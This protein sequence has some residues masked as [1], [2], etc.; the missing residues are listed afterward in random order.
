MHR[1]ALVLMITTAITL[2]LKGV[3]SEKSVQQEERPKIGLA[4]SGGGARGAAHIGVIRVLGELNIPIDYIAGT[5]MGS[6][7]GGLYA[8]GMST[9]EME[10]QLTSVDWLASFDDVSKR[11]DKT[12]RRKL[13]DS[14]YLVKHKA[15]ISDEG[16]LK[17]PGGILQGQR[18]DLLLSKFT[19]PVSHVKN[20]DKLSIPFRAVAADIETGDSVV[21]STGSLA[22]A[23]RASMN[24]PG[25][26]A[27]VTIDGK[28]LVDGGVA[29]NLPINVVR[30]MGADI[31]IAIDISTP[32]YNKEQLKNV[33]NISGQLVG[34]LTRKNTEYSLATLTKKDI[35]IIPQ[36]GDIGTGDFE[37]AGET[38]PVGEKAARDKTS[39]LQRLKLP[40]NQ[41]ELH[42]AKRGQRQVAAP[43]IAFI[44]VDN[45]SRLH[46]DVIKSKVTHKTGQPLDV[47]QI[48]N[49]IGRIYGLNQFENV[50][51]ELVEENGESGVVIHAVEKNW[52]PNY[53]QF[54]IIISDN[55]EGDNSVNL[56]AAY[57]RTGI[58]RLNGEWRTALQV[59]EDPL[60]LTEIYQPL[61][62]ANKFFINASAF[63]Q[64]RNLNVFQSAGNQ[65]G[66]YRV[67][68]LATS[69]AVGMNFDTWGELRFGIRRTSGEA[70]VRVGGSALSD[71]NFDSGSFL[72]RFSF[73]TI[74]D[75]YFPKKGH[76]GLL[77]GRFFSNSLGGDDNFD[78]L[79]LE[80][81]RAK[82]WGRN[83]FL[84]GLKY[85]TTL[86]DD[87]PIY[88]LFQIGGFTNL[89]G[90]NQGELTGQHTGVLRLG[91]LRRIND[92]KLL[93]TYFGASL[94][95]GGAWQESGDIFDEG[96]AAASIFIGVDSPI[97]PI[98]TGYGHAEG[99]NDSL[100]FFL[101]KLF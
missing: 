97:G 3:A 26:F 96:T 45:Q 21:L 85:S 79:R 35:V 71:F 52:G 1:I 9:D 30:E 68:R 12:F 65:I 47:A 60:L 64:Q 28:L 22:K 90:F 16:E 75:A 8:S 27:P 82:T 40:K 80:Y 74:D 91:Y 17:L 89:S 99:G 41:Y 84:A 18:I 23:M 11:E 100:Y 54:G 77:E 59:G 19:L 38:I 14:L 2:P 49:D 31:V 48:E 43:N 42:L 24:I 95:Y 55:F 87:A 56:G 88:G 76:V 13:D 44:R 69:F 86:D 61:D 37:R 63:A 4:L 94:E 98:Y 46:D 25:A 32:L 70:D 34:L 57:T 78:Q 58:N 92:F 10:K 6:I 36:L 39:V 83:T 72:T 81:L 62:Y 66:E 53:L 73:D 29:N 15:G 93:P 33:L 51:Y 101:G 67:D 7:I 5:S 50:N 20:F